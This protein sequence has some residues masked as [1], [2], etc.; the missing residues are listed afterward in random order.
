MFKDVTSPI[1]LRLMPDAL[2]WEGSAL[3]KRPCRP[4]FFAAFSAVVGSRPARSVRILE[5][6]SGPGFLA[7]RLLED[8]PHVSYIALDFSPAMHELAAKR[9]AAFANR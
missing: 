3:T 1:N 6:G 4:Q 5:L 8:H 2:A 9:L 7:L